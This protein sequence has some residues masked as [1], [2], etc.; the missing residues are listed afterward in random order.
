MAIAVKVKGLDEYI[1]ALTVAPA[2]IHKE[3]RIQFKEELEAIDLE[4]QHNHN[5]HTQSGNLEKSIDYEVSGDGLTGEI[6]LDKTKASAPYAW[7]IHEGFQG[8]TDSLGRHFNG[9]PPDQFLYDAAERK[10]DQLVEAMSD[11]VL[12]GCHNAGL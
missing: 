4:A 11:A 1:A 7:R 9:P 8:M 5:Y 6:W 10:T 3:I 12:R 2:E